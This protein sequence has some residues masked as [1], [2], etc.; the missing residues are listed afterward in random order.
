MTALSGPIVFNNSGSGSDSA[1]S[2]CGPATPIS[3]MLQTSAGS[4][5]ANASWS[6]TISVGDLIYVPANTGRKFNVVAVVGSGSLTFDDNWDDS[7]MGTSGYV[8]GKRATLEGSLDLFSTELGTS[9]IVELETD[10]TLTSRLEWVENTARCNLLFRSDTVGT[11]RTITQTSNSTGLFKGDG[12]WNNKTLITFQD[13]KFLNTATTKARCFDIADQ[14]GHETYTLIRCQIG[15]TGSGF[16]EGIRN[17]NYLAVNCHDCQF[18]D[19]NY[20][21]YS[22]WGSASR[23][24]CDRCLFSNCTYGVYANWKQLQF[25][26][27]IFDN[28]TDGLEFSLYG[29]TVNFMTPFVIRGCIFYGCTTGI[30]VL[31]VADSE[32]IIFMDNIFVSNTT[33]ITSAAALEVDA[34]RI[35]FYGNGTDIGGSFTI[36]QHLNPIALTADPFVSAST[37]DFNLNAD[38]GGGATLRS[39]NYTLGG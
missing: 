38:A 35:A 22:W 25:T 20:A 17:G 15:D 37:G 36:D 6:G 26:N 19:C 27:C 21:F 16:T 10:Q 30:N 13:I 31:S 5:V 24:T 1:A 4:N 2:G 14:T 23:I 39:T 7:Q 28:C 33:A 34:A 3:V 9:Q 29:T 8:G 11:K 32:T 18:I 12:A